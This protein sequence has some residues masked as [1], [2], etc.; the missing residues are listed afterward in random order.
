[1]SESSVG[2]PAVTVV[3]ELF[4]SQRTPE[5]SGTTHKI[6]VHRN[7]VDVCKPFDQDVLLELRDRL[8]HPK[9]IPVAKQKGR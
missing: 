9:P 5:S 1:M 2:H 8:Q 7:A 6:G 4:F 3:S